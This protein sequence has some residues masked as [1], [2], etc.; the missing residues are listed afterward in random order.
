MEPVRP[1]VDAFVLD[2]LER[3]TFRKVY[4]TET[5]VG[6]VRLR[7]PLT[8]ELAETMPRWAQSLAPVAEKVAHDLG[9]VMAGK[10][11]R[12]TPL[13]G[14]NQRA[15][16]AAVKARRE[17]TRRASH[18]TAPRQQPSTSSGVPHW[19]CPDCGG[20]VTNTQHVRCDA[21]I[22]ADASQ[23]PEVRGR[24]GRAIAARRRVAAEWDIAH[25]DEPYDP[26]RFR[27]D[28]LPALA[29]VKLAEIMAVT[30]WSK[31]FASRVRAGRSIPHVSTW[32]ALTVLGEVVRPG[33]T[34]R[35]ASTLPPVV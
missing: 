28:I 25:G 2:L 20:Q 21:C 35:V 22:A 31:S 17:A 7:A 9:A 3:R 10:Y 18:S 27:R 15:A 13:S 29:D 1:E 5:S 19:T 12:A 23:T 30:G 4:F 8:H 14:R 11:T 6:H 33:A 26:E 16:Q 24:R 34:R 32:P